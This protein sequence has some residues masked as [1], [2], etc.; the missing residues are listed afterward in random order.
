MLV[1]NYDGAHLRLVLDNV[2]KGLVTPSS[3]L[4]ISL[5]GLILGS[6]NL[7]NSSFAGS[8]ARVAFF[9]SALTLGQIASLWAAATAGGYDAQ[10]LALM[11]VRYFKLTETSGRVAY[12]SSASGVNAIY[13][14]AGL[15]YGVAGP[16]TGASS[17]TLG[18]V[19]S[20]SPVTPFSA[21]VDQTASRAIGTTYVNGGGR[22][23]TVHVTCTCA[24]TVTDGATFGAHTTVGGTAFSRNDQA[25]APAG[26][27]VSV[28]ASLTFEVDPGASYS[29]A[30]AVGGAS[31]VTLVH[32]DETDS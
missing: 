8:M 16:I 1:V 21:G 30:S 17:S 13:N 4:N 3:A 26:V 18:Y 7:G 9:A 14:S 12:D 27:I 29:V 23:R 6:D 28:V 20:S 24:A 32:W 25:G 22:R 2:D 10:V 15:T 5:Y 31:T 19:N 11:P